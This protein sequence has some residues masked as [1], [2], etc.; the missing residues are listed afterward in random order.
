MG[1][2]YELFIKYK[3]TKDKSIRDELVNRYIYIAKILAYK[4]TS[5]GVEYDDLYQV[6]CVGIVLALDR[7]DPDRGVQFATFAKSTVMGEIRRFLRDK[8][9]CI[10]VPRNLY[11]T[12]C[13]AEK[14]RKQSGTLSV[15]EL[16]KQLN[17]PEKTLEEAYE[18]WDTT[19]IKSLEDDAYEDGDAEV[20]S[21][22]GCDDEGYNVIENRDFLDYCM[23]KLEEK[24]CELFKKR[25][26]DGKTQRKTAEEMNVSQM[27]VSR[28]E[29]KIIN[30]LKDILKNEADS[31]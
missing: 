1:E 3:E 19:F 25:F 28:A 14:L 20:S 18:A 13:K 6:A 16:S 8:V 29:K 17:V 7:F 24:E 9:R 27:Y 21:L 23:S 11:E 10:K 26:F 12:L 15:K 5:V 22:V 2:E 30:K 4:S 31:I